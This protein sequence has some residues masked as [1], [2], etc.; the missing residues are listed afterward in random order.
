MLWGQTGEGFEYDQVYTVAERAYGPDVRLL[1]GLKY[2]YTYLSASGTPFLEGCGDTGDIRVNGTI[3]HDQPLR[4]DIL[5]QQLILDYKDFSGGKGSIVLS[6]EQVDYFY[7][8]SC[9]FR[10]YLMEEGEV[11]FCQVIFEGTISCIYHWNKEYIAKMNGER[12]YYFSDPRR[13][14]WIVVGEELRQYKG[15]ASFL[16]AIPPELKNEAKKYL[17]RH[18]IRFRRISQEKMAE[19]MQHINTLLR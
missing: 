7:L 2:N 12:T 5:N 16:S 1:S 3:Y 19:V 11:Q 6:K 10:P 4:F 17:K 13:K 15:R 18:K 14:K 8:G 9:L